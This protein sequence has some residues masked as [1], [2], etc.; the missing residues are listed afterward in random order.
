MPEI[1]DAYHIPIYIYKKHIFVSKTCSSKP[2]QQ[3]GQS[4]D[5]K[6]KTPRIQALD[7]KKNEMLAED[8]F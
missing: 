7:V 5:V 4:R 2:S 6:K 3:P 1:K 8:I